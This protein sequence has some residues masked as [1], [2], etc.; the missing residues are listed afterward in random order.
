MIQGSTPEVLNLSCGYL[1]S[2]Y[3]TNINHHDIKSTFTLMEMICMRFEQLAFLFRLE[4]LPTNRHHCMILLQLFL[5]FC[6]LK[7]V[8]H[9]CYGS[10]SR[11]LHNQE[12][13]LIPVKGKYS[14]IK[15]R[16]KSHPGIKEYIL[17]NIGWK[18]NVDRSSKFVDGN[19]AKN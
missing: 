17:K 9:Q 4:F 19:K 5:I 18:S 15:E 16:K 7:L 6:V 2:I 14:T 1:K 3:L 11:R 8:C 10:G 13:I 12:Q